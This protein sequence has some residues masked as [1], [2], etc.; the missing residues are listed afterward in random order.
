MVRILSRRLLQS[1]IVLFL[2]ITAL[3]F[4]VQIIMVGDAASYIAFLNPGVSVTADDIREELGLDLPIGQRYLLWLG[5]ILRGD[6]GRSYYEGPSYS[7][8][9]SIER[10]PVFQALWRGLLI[11]LFIFGIGT[12]ISFRIGEWLGKIIA[13]KRARTLSG[14][15][16]SIGIMFHT[17]FPPVLAWIFYKINNKGGGFFSSGVIHFEVWQERWLEDMLW[18]PSTFALLLFITFVVIGLVVIL[19]KKLIENRYRR[20]IHVLLTIGVMLIVWLGGWA[21]IGA[22][23]RLVDIIRFLGAGI[24]IYVLLAFG[25]TMLVMQSSM[26]DTLY[27]EYIFAARAKGLPENAI[28]DKHAAPN[29][30]LPVLSRLIIG[31]PYLLTGLVMIENATGIGGMGTTLF[32]SLGLM[33]IPLLMGCLLV[34]GLITIVTRLALDLIITYLDPRIRRISAFSEATRR[35]VERR[36]NKFFQGIM[37]WITRREGS[38]ELQIRQS[39]VSGVS[40]VAN[41]S[42][43]DSLRH[44]LRQRKAH[45]KLFWNQA[46]ESWGIYSNN[47]LAVFGLILIFIFAIMAILH[48]I[49]M[50]TVWTPQ[51]Y[52]PMVGYDLMIFTHPSPPS[53]THPLGTDSLGRDVM[54]ILLASTP[55]SFAVAISASLTAAVVGILIGAV[56]AYYQNTLI[57]TLLGYIADV[58]LIMPVPIV[59]VIIG[60][61]YFDLG[62]ALFGVIYGVMIGASSMA[63]V[64]RTQALKVL[65]KPFIEAAQTSGA[66]ARRIIFGHLIPHILPLAS[67]QMMIA[68]AGAV[69][70]YG[71]ISFV[72][73]INL[74]LN[75]GSMVYDAI[76]FSEG[77][78]FSTPWFQLLSPGIAL[79]LF[80]ASFYFIS[81]GLHQ[82]AEPRLRL[83]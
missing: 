30:I 37:Q 77:F 73:L 4:L 26:T 62:P 59:M 76:T 80:A 41:K 50:K 21:S 74:D 60:T 34:I 78:A 54:S 65:T 15:L 81:R 2:F 35:P 49:L 72:G 17:A 33:D 9:G 69:I 20:R 75:W 5:Q 42:P 38:E 19:V 8:D 7:G 1:A 58:L 53:S 56:S 22:W 36:R 24:I 48:P 31:L 44:W 45:T 28:R 52:D 79:S 40:S 63:I 57:D 18:R 43:I 12:I 67:V 16:T 27:E 32:A 6:L 47:K 3:F 46:K 10:V 66:G 25:E 61:R 83:R 13:W 11:S 39:R 68:V 70:S 71:F 64:L 55:S 14:V 82:V 23:G 51:V 29:A